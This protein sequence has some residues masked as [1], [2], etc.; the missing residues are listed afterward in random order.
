MIAAASSAV[1]ALLSR[2]RRSAPARRRSI[3]NCEERRR[4][5]D[6]RRERGRVVLPEVTGVAAGRQVG[7][8]DLHLVGLLPLVP[9]FGG[10]LAGAVGVVCEHDLAGEILE[11]LEVLVGQRGPAR[12]DGVGCAGER[13][14]HHVGVAL[15]DHDIAARHDLALGPVEPVE[16]ATLLVDRR[17]GRVLVLRHLVAERATPEAGRLAPR[18]VDREHEPRPELV[19]Q[20]VGAVHER[21][22]GVD[23]VLALE[24]FLLEVHAQRVEPVRS[25]TQVEAPGGVAVEAPAPEMLAPRPALGR[26]DEQAVVERDRGADDLAEALLALSVLADGDVVVPERDA[27]SRREPFDGFDEVEMLDLL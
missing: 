23:D 15:A 7:H 22:P 16:Q 8:L 26:F 20:L 17:L 14:R 3:R 25:P 6:R 18:V 13:E 2:V 1:R 11:D 19:L 27:G 9:A 12:G 5:L 4:P 24:A 10:R 21:E